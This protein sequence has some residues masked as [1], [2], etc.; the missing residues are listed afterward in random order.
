MDPAFFKN[1]YGKVQNITEEIWYM[2]SL[3]Q[4]CWVFSGWGLAISVSVYG[5]RETNP[6]ATIR[7]AFLDSL[8]DDIFDSGKWWLWGEK[9]SD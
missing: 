5:L 3:V 1:Y 4:N 6:V 2:Y 9:K 7:V 8:T